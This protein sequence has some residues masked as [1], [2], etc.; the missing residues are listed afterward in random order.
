MSEFK[1]LPTGK[2]SVVDT[3]D[4]SAEIDSLS[5]SIQVIDFAHHKIHEGDSFCVSHTLTA[6]NDGTYLTIYL[7]TP[8]AEKSIHMFT[9]WASSGA[10]YF[11]IREYPVVT[12]NTGS[13]QLSVNRNRNST[14]ISEALDNATVPI[15]G[16]AMTDV[17]ISD[18]TADVAGS[19][20]GLIIWQEYD[21]I[22]KQMT[23]G[24]RNDS[25]FILKK[26]TPY[27]F[28]LESDASGLVLNANLYWY[29]T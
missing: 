11:R 2:V 12:A 3:E 26:N 9:Q 10:S 28:E 22:G 19:K 5:G 4:N 25:E 8:N 17:T 15:A 6:K 14:N 21:G 20:G 18:R 29:E 27:V 16:Y 13:S 1:K 7:K 24:N 23:G